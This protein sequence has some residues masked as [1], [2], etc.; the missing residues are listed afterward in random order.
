MVC[1]HSRQHDRA[2]DDLEHVAQMD[3]WES[4]KKK[5]RG[6]DWMGGGGGGGLHNVKC[7]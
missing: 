2:E 5:R 1:L 3:I 4:G 6:R 7:L